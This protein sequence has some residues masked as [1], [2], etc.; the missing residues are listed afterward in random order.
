MAVNCEI[1][2]CVYIKSPPGFEPDRISYS[3]TANK[4]Y[5]DAYTRVDDGAYIIE[6]QDS[7]VIFIYLNSATK[8]RISSGKF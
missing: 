3:A 7:L 4:L 5:F 1:S 6:S 2:K 8:I